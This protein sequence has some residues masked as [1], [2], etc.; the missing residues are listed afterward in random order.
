[1]PSLSIPTSAPSRTANEELAAQIV[2][3][4][5]TAEFITG[6]D[7]GAVSALLTTGNAKAGDWRRLLEKNLPTTT[8]DTDHAAA[9]HAA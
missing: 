8:I 2:A 4:L 1:M 3:A 5:Q 9:H 7:M 6:S